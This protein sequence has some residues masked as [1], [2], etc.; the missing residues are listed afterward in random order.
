MRRM[1]VRPWLAVRLLRRRLRP[2]RLRLLLLRCQDTSAWR[3]RTNRRSRAH[4][5][6][7]LGLVPTAS[8]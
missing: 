5:W 1:Q 6:L 8:L 4:V 3:L 7:V 2:L